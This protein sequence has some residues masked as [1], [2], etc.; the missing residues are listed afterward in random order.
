[1][2]EK[3]LPSEISVFPLP[4]AVLF[5][6]V[7]LPLRIFEPRYLKMLRHVLD[8]TG[9]LAIG[10]LKSDREFNAKGHPDIFPTVGLGRVVD[11]QKAADGT[12]KIVLLG[13][14]RVRM[15]S[16]SQVKPFPIGQLEHML[17]REPGD[18]LRDDIR[19][20]LRTRIRELVRTTVDSQVLMLLDQTIKE[21]EEIG[22]LVDSI[23]YHFLN[24]P[25]EKQ[26]LLEVSDAVQREQLL[27]KILEKERFGTATSDSTSD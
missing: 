15:Q 14:H 9:W 6:K 23:A 24:S 8:T 11:Y 25:V 2:T 5:P 4:N 20:R 26:R 16:W 7:L 17:E 10:L 22:P 3:S 12:Y 27:I 1:M 13:E 18:E 21:C 19:V